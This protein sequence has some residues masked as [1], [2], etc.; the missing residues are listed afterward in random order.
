MSDFVG[1]SRR[2]RWIPGRQSKMTWQDEGAA[3]IVRE[4][5]DILG[6]YPPNA[7]VEVVGECEVSMPLTRDGLAIPNGETLYLGGCDP[8]QEWD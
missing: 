7:D 4:V 1:M 3:M 6:R 2:K 8:A 5:I